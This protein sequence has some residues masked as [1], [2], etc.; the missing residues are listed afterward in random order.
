MSPSSEPRAGPFT[1]FPGSHQLLGLLA[2]K[3][4]IPVIHALARGTRR[5]GEL[6]REIGDV[7]Q[8]MLTQCV[9]RL[10]RHGLLVRT[11]Y[12]EVPPRVEYRLTPLGLS[13]NQPLAGL[14]RWV[15]ENGRRLERQV[16]RL[17][18]LVPLASALALPA[19][20]QS[21]AA[22]AREVAAAERS[23]TASMAGRDLAG[24]GESI[25][26]LEPDGRG[27]V[28]SDKG[29]PACPPAP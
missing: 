7:S 17:A 6:H 19:A 5:F 12:A 3:W 15:E 22:L 18:V 23:F 13:L 20:A 27:R 11:V 9:R 1:R 16:I 25:W 29:A 21:H 8:K 14:C 26:R 2:D 4:T 10:E 24:F 28:V